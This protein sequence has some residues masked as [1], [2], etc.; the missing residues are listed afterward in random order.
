MAPLFSTW[1][2]VPLLLLLSARAPQ[3]KKPGAR[4]GSTHLHNA[5]RRQN[6]MTPNSIK[7]MT[8]LSGTPSSHRMIG[9]VAS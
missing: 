6:E 2:T 4:P 5:K 9:I 1:V 7:R 3:W 8:M